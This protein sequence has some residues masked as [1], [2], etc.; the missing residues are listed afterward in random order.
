M[1][2]LRK[3]QSRLLLCSKAYRNLLIGR[4]GSRRDQTQYVNFGWPFDLLSEF[5]AEECCE[6][7]VG[8]VSFHTL[9]R[10]GRLA[11]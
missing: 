5:N 9:F 6:E 2:E 3:K 10:L 4:K 11:R 1:A 7:A 8:E